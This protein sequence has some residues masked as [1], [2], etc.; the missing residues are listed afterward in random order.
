[1]WNI[2]VYIDQVVDINDIY[3]YIHFFLMWV[4]PLVHD[5]IQVIIQ[6][7]MSSDMRWRLMTLPSRH[8]IQNWGPG[9]LRPTASTS[10]LGHKGSSQ[11]W[12]FTNKKKHFVSLTHKSQSEVRISDLRLSKPAALTTAPRPPRGST[13]SN[14]MHHCDNKSFF[15]N[16]A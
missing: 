15:S 9:G 12:V 6:H 8:R 4:S 11:Y 1:M 10:P 2:F 3:M 5:A 14:T 16:K 7:S 13:C